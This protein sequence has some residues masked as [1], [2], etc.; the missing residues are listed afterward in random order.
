MNCEMFESRLNEL[1]DE[2][3]PL[4]LDGTLS[5]HARRCG[6]CQT[7]LSAYR[8]LMQAVRFPNLPE[9]SDDLTGRVVAAALRE[10]SLAVGD[11]TSAD[12]ASPASSERNR[13]K[14]H[15]FH[16]HVWRVAALAVCTAVLVAVAWKF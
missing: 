7:L 2:R 13:A 12:S 3:A 16:K 6:R 4:E 10:E 11:A 8:E 5:A 15:R 9:P 14:T 1:L